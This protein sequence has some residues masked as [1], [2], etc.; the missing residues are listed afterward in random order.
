MTQNITIKQAR[1]K[2]GNKAENMTDKQVERVINF[3]YT[4]CG[5]VAD[6][7]VE[8]RPNET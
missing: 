2:L 4:L 6:L 3:L 8:R 5:W 7:A 1:L